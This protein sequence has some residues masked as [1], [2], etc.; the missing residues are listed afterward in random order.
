M[1]SLVCSCPCACVLCALSCLS[2]LSCPVRPSRPVPTDCTRIAWHGT[3][4]E[5]WWAGLAWEAPTV[6]LKQLALLK[7]AHARLTGVRHQY[8][9]R[10]VAQS[11][12]SEF[13][14]TFALNCVRCAKQKQSQSDTA[15]HLFL[16]IQ[17][18]CK[19]RCKFT[20]NCTM[21]S[22]AMTMATPFTIAV[23]DRHLTSP[24]C[25]QMWGRYV[26]AD[27]DASHG[28]AS[29]SGHCIQRR[30]ARAL[31]SHRCSVMHGTS[32]RHRPPCTRGTALMV[33]AVG[34][35]GARVRETSSAYS[36]PA[37]GSDQVRWSW[38]VRVREFTAG[39]S[40]LD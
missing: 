37:R 24:P 34:R 4:T 33:A 10:R 21:Q 26:S 3:H 22:S 32:S 25:M 15:H 18:R 1:C 19:L 29:G 17:R 8:S 6:R 9:S 16:V 7:L 38:R 12:A 40:E 13:A 35:A 31:F 5:G 20:Q 30:S 36:T 2:H 14:A 27:Q 28:C 39:Q 11:F 23:C